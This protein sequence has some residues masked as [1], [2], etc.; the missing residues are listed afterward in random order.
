MSK[1]M[2]KFSPDVR[3]SPALY[4]ERNRVER[5]FNRIKHFHRVAIL[6]SCL[7]ASW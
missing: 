5:F 1:T 2:N 3:V 6:S 7:R 4:R